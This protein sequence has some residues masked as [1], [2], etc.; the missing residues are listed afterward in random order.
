MG[1]F[2]V[3]S[4]VRDGELRNV[5]FENI[6]AARQ[7]DENG[8]VVAAVLGD[9]D[10]ESLGQE[11]IQYGA[12]RAVV[13]QHENL[14]IILLM[15]MSKLQWLSLS[16]KIQTALLWD[17]HLKGKTCHQESQVNWTVD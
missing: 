7:I 13:V 12:D 4:E 17:T 5:S 8:E 9:G 11:L 1:K 16:K 10:L 15:D 3:I 2:L 14:K 6:A